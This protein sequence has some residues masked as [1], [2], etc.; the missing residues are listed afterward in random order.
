VGF[1]VEAVDITHPWAVVEEDAPVWDSIKDLAVATAAR[2]MGADLAG[3]FRFRTPFATGYSDPASLETITEV[4]SVDSEILSGRPNRI[5]VHGVYVVKGTALRQ[6][7]D[8]RSSQLWEEDLTA[9]TL[10]DGEQWPSPSLLGPFWAKY[11]DSAIPIN[12]RRF[13]FRIF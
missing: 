3:C 5:V 9:I 2:Y 1:D 11:T 6:L 4:V 8:L 7:W 13:Y 10:L 12:Y